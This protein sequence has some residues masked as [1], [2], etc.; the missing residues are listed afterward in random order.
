MMLTIGALNFLVSSSHPAAVN[1]SVALAPAI[2]LIAFALL[3]IEI[4]KPL[5]FKKV[6]VPLASPIKETTI[7][8]VAAT[9]LSFFIP[10]AFLVVLMM[11]NR[12]AGS[13]HIVP[14]LTWNGYMYALFYT[15]LSYGLTALIWVWRPSLLSTKNLYQ[16]QLSL[17]FGLTIVG[18]A[19]FEDLFRKDWSSFIFSQIGVLGI[20]IMTS[21]PGTASIQPE[22]HH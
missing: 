20:L 6:A 9:S 10:L 5:R 21:Y 19:C 2:A 17:L 22:S 8:A 11:W 13:Q 15:G 16:P 4:W 1:Y 7:L 12:A 14:A 18:S 3:F